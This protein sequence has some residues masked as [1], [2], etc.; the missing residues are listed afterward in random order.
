[1]KKN[2]WD[3]KIPTI[4]GLLIISI[5]LG[6]TTFLVNQ[7]SLFGIKANPSKQ[8]QNVRITNITDT[9]FSVSYTTDD[10]VAG[11]IA[12]G[13]T[14]NISQ[15]ALDDKDQQSGNVQ[16]HKIHNIS[17]TNLSPETIYYFNIRSG[18]QVYKNND[19]SFQVTT[20]PPLSKNPSDQKPI[21]GKVILLDGSAPQEGILYVTTNDSQVISTEIKSDGTYILPLNSLRNS[22]LASFY[23]FGQ[24]SILKM[25]VFG[26]NLTSNVTL[27]INQINPVPTITLSSDYNFISNNE[28]VASSSANIQTFPIFSSK[29]T[30]TG[31]ED[32]QI[33]TPEQDQSFTDQQPQFKGTALPGESVQIIIH[34]DEQIQTTVKANS[35]GDWTYRPPS[36]LSPGEHTITILTKGADGVLKSITE[37]FVVYA[38][39]QQVN[40]A[41]PS[42]TPTPTKKPTPTPTQK[43]T[44][45]PT[46]TKTVTQAPTKTPTPTLSPVPTKTVTQTPTPTKTLIAAL[47]L[48]PTPTLIPTATSFI[49]ASP[50]ATQTS[51]PPTGNPS[52]VTIGIIGMLIALVG[53]LLFLLTRGSIS[54]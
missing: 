52:I 6:V 15:T 42:G 41:V 14:S 16:N 18:D 12:Y 38:Q 33:L 53:G 47:T 44:A 13:T 49:I 45:T 24:N 20:G 30:S 5:G 37:S 40:P 11:S 17:L 54:I 39:G 28:P 31:D 51:L 29:S 3:K 9:A 26:D 32:P 10:N 8:P 34:S 36:P 50:T 21:V 4:L 22:D 23:N 35:S 2:F 27:S 7:P 25:L 43:P 19:T 1:M 46:P 48:T